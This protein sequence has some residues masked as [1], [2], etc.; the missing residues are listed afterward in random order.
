MTGHWPY[1]AIGL[2][3]TAA[4]LAWPVTS[5]IPGHDALTARLAAAILAALACAAIWKWPHIGRRTAIA[6]C[7][8]SAFGAAALLVRHFDALSACI[9]DFEERPVIV[10]TVYTPDVQAYLAAN[11]GLS[12]SDRLFDAGGV[13][14][15]VWTADSIRS[16]RRL[17]SWAGLAAIPLL[18]VSAAALIRTTRYAL[19]TTRQAIPDR[20][21]VPGARPAYD[22]FISYRHLEP[23]RTLALDLVGTLEGRGLRVAIDARDFAPNEHFLSE[24]ERCIRQSRFVL[25]VLT[26]R[27]VESDHTTEEAIISRTFDLAERRKRLV[28]LIFERVELPVW[29]HG[30]VGIDFTAEAGVDPHERLVGLLAVRQQGA[31]VTP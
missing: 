24:M 7:A 17:V 18:A 13:P 30:L 5:A 22:A 26:S 27:Y 10:G 9:V 1:V 14:E 15:R 11:P 8:L 21:P 6:V 4:A 20:A 28:P 16:C 3:A 25:C 29:L 19:A 2:A 23:D 31:A 12:A